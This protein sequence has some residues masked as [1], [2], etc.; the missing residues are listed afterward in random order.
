M[1]GGTGMKI[2]IS[3]EGLI[4]AIRAN[5][6]MKRLERFAHLCIR[7]GIRDLYALDHGIIDNEEM[8]FIHEMLTE[9]VPDIY[10]KKEN[11]HDS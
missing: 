9:L 1:K 8:D 7:I 6:Q 10:E 5:G 11:K 3:D 2:E 4:E